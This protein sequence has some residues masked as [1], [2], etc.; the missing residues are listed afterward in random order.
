VITPTPSPP[1]S[2]IYPPEQS[3]P[4][5]PTD[6]QIKCPC[7]EKL[8]TVN[9]AC[10]ND[11]EEDS[12]VLYKPDNETCTTPTPVP[13]CSPHTSPNHPP[14]RPEAD[15]PDTKGSTQSTQS[16]N[17]LM[18]CRAWANSAKM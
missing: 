7:C 4:I 10:D 11:S 17:M 6:N 5:D 9:H 14:R 16:L 15:P 2:F 3:Q 8:M 1:S 18:A 13:N 12:L